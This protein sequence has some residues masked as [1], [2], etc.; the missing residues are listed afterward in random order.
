M[1]LHKIGLHKSLSKHLIHD[2]LHFEY[3]FLEYLT[4]NILKQ[5]AILKLYAFI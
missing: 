5:F 3:V 2:L 4:E 1:L